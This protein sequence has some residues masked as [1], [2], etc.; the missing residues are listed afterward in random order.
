MR[1]RSDHRRAVRSPSPCFAAT[2]WHDRRRE[3]ASA[4]A[5]RRA[6]RGRESRRRRRSSV[7]R[8]G[9]TMAARQSTREPRSQAQG[10]G[11]A[12][13]DESQV[14]SI[15][16]SVRCH[17]VNA[18]RHCGTDLDANPTVRRHR[19]STGGLLCWFGEHPRPELEPCS[20]HDWKRWFWCKG[21]ST[22]SPT[23]T[24]VATSAS[25]AV[26]SQA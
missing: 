22:A 7:V 6:P 25:V 10:H 26:C 1:L 20:T 15:H 16:G 11:M 13:S 14:A 12:A 18:C 8:L 17:P 24:F 21:V 3:R 9:D 4:E 19:R 5:L 23:C 2:R